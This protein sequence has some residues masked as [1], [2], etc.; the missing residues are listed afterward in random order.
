MAQQKE[1]S[2]GV[3][4]RNERE[5]GCWQDVRQGWHSL[6]K[7]ERRSVVRCSGEERQSIDSNYRCNVPGKLKLNLG[8]VAQ[9]LTMQSVIIHRELG[10]NQWR[11]TGS[12]SSS[13]H[14]LHFFWSK[15]KLH[16]IL[17]FLIF[18]LLFFWF[19]SC[20]AVELTYGRV[21]AEC[22]SILVSVF[23]NCFKATM[24]VWLLC[25]SKKH[26]KTAPKKQCSSLKQSK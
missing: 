21:I 23:V 26:E 20:I 15:I 4:G 1:W 3:S 6:P 12:N 5:K 11:Q 19:T 14:H 25:C 22:V 7:N 17:L 2:D 24:T 16:S 18:S 8:S 13:A 10:D 9:Q